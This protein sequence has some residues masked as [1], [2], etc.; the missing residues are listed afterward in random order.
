MYV[1]TYVFVSTAISYS[2]SDCISESPFNVIEI[3]YA[4]GLFVTLPLIAL[5]LPITFPSK[6]LNFPFVSIITPYLSPVIIGF[7]ILT[8][9]SLSF[10]PIVKSPVLVTFTALQFADDTIFPSPVE[11]IILN[12]PFTVIVASDISFFPVTV[13]PQRSNN[14]FFPAGITTDSVTSVSIS[15]FVC[16]SSAFSG[17]AAIAASRVL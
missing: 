2:F 8:I 5:V 6:K 13:T 9:G 4:F 10:V 17:H 12:L 11:S 1:I 7:V 16:V 14:T 3:S 15:I